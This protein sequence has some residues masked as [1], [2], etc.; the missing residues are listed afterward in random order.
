MSRRIKCKRSAMRSPPGPK[1]KWIQDFDRMLE[2]SSDGP[3]ESPPA[4]NAAKVSPAE[5]WDTMRPYGRGYRMRRPDRIFARSVP[6]KLLDRMR[7]YSYTVKS[8]S[9]RN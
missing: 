6:T 8:R 7:S 2:D 1:S 3:H 9:I 5:V 4:A